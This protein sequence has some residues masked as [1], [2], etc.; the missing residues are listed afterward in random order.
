HAGIPTRPSTE[1]QRELWAKAVI[2]SSINPLTAFFQ[3]PNG[4]L[5]HNPLLEKTVTLIC[6]E[7]TRVATA[8]GIPLTID[9][10]IQRTK[11]VIHD[12]TENTS[13]MLQ[14]V[15]QGKQTEIAS[16]N[17]RLITVGKQC[18]VQTPLNEIL[19]QLITNLTTRR[20]I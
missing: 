1:I 2:N 10:M 5:L 13:S 19:L 11:K 16:I 17:G 14:S 18:G 9:D 15:R 8:H 7:S 6:E 3:C 12:T 20:S 4:Y